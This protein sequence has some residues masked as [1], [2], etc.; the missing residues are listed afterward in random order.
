MVC[1]VAEEFLRAA[2]EM[3]EYT[4]RWGDDVAGKTYLTPLDTRQVL[5]DRQRNLVDMYP[6][7]AAHDMAAAHKLAE[8]IPACC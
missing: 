4:G 8:T 2:R 1:T 3:L 6:R 5:E 7:L